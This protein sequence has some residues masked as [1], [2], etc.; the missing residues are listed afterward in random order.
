MNIGLFGGTF[1]PIHKGHLALAVAARERCDLG[2][3]Y[4]V[5]TN[6]PPHKTSQPV[7]SYF[8]RYAMTA[9]A[10]ERER[11]FVPSLLEAPGE[12]V[13]HDKKSTK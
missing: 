6:V 2:R 10:T 1:D 8:H 9:L 5:P 3:V 13:L 4:F 12:F 11:P 7:A